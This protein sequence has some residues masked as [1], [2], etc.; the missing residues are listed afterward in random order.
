MD[1]YKSWGFYGTPFDTKPL[2]PDDEG[3]KLLVGRDREIRQIQKRLYSSN[4]IITV[5]GD[6]GIGKTS[7]T[8]IAAYKLYENVDELEE[9]DTLFIPCNAIFQ[10]TNEDEVSDFEDEVLIAI[11]QTLIT[12]AKKLKD[13]G[14]NL[15]NLKGINSWINQTYI[16]EIQA[17]LTL[18]GF[19]GS[20]GGAKTVQDTEGLRKSGLKKQILD[21]LGAIFPLTRGGGVICI[22]DNLEL[23]ET[24]IV[25][26][27]QLEKLRDTLFTFRG[28]KWI[29]CGSLGII[30]GVM[31]SPRLEGRLHDPIDIRQLSIDKAGEVYDARINLFSMFEDTSKNLPLKKNHFEL[32]YR[33]LNG[34]LRSTLQYSDDYCMWFDDRYGDRHDYSALNNKFHEWIKEITVKRCDAVISQIGKKPIQ[35]FITACRVHS[36][37]FTLNDFKTFNLSL[38]TLNKHSKG[39]EA[40]NMVSFN[41][42]DENNRPKSIE[43]TSSGWFILDYI[44]KRE[45]TKKS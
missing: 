32:L 19:G 10:L 3:V 33:K 17:G 21:W 30:R 38:Q 35:T 1:I 16:N 31:S 20:L 39:L 6:N 13:Q 25:A 5:E 22:L 24:S 43:V 2:L 15:P 12:N 45:V 23:L 29:L 4:S 14:V 27:K 11:A 41:I 42:P 37:K 34:N 44:E 28:I 36:G 8:N 9:L 26:R 7:L 40:V 18:F